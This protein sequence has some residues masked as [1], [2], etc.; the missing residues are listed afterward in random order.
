ME[1][2]AEEEINRLKETLAA[3]NLKMEQIKEDYAGRSDKLPVCL[4]F[5]E[6]VDE[7]LWVVLRSHLVQRHVGG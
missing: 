5:L 1:Q 4:G 7:G 2:G 3:I 6:Q